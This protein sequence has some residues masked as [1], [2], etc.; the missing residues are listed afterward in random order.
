[1]HVVQGQLPAEAGP[2]HANGPAE[3]TLS[4]ASQ[5]VRTTAA[6]TSIC[7]SRRSSPGKSLFRGGPFRIEGR[8]VWRDGRLEVVKEV[9]AIQRAGQKA[10]LA[11][12]MLAEPEGKH[13]NRIIA[14]SERL[15]SETSDLAAGRAGRKVRRR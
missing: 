10:L 2:A 8:L 6:I 1:M 13:K 15:P 14:R 12:L 3:R 7:A 5:N 9:R 11:E 4:A